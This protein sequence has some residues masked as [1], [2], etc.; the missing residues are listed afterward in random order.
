MQ[1]KRP[2]TINDS[3]RGLLL[4]KA[5]FT[6][7]LFPTL[8]S[9]YVAINSRSILLPCSSVKSSGP[10]QKDRSTPMDFM[11]NLALNVY[12]VVG[13]DLP[14]MWR[15]CFLTSHVLRCI[16]VIANLCQPILLYNFVVLLP[17]PEWAD[18]D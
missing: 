13:Y 3:F 5:A 18:Y 6:L 15:S 7:A 11:F 9:F 1:Q 14:C 17:N 2:L 8:P 10:S 4:A 12:G 16:R